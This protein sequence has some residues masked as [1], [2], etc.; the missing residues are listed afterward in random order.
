MGCWFSSA[1]PREQLC[2]G[3]SR[4]G[5]PRDRII[6]VGKDPL[7]SSYARLKKED[8]KMPLV[9]SGTALVPS[10]PRSVLCKRKWD[11]LGRNHPFPS[12]YKI[13]T[14][15]HHT[16]LGS[17]VPIPRLSRPPM[18]PRNNS[19]RKGCDARELPR[20]PKATSPEK[21]QP[22]AVTPGRNPG[23]PGTRRTVI[24]NSSVSDSAVES[25]PRLKG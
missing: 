19:S 3:R 1:H 6:W 21:Q 4:A 13:T 5:G 16:A 2:N 23:T 18:A 7:R 12:S 22:R 9:Q 15:Q 10:P 11:K 14:I 25:A 20:T 17:R 8:H 24:S